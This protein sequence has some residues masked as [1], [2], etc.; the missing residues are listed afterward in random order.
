MLRSAFPHSHKMGKNASVLVG[1]VLKKPKILGRSRDA[2][3]QKGTTVVNCYL[4]F[5][6][7]DDLQ[8]QLNYRSEESPT[9]S[10]HE[11]TN[12]DQNEHDELAS[13]LVQEKER[14]REIAEECSALKS[15]L[16]Q[17]E[18]AKQVLETET[19]NLRLEAEELRE[20]VSDLD[21]QL[22]ESGEVCKVSEQR[23][24]EERE[25]C[26]KL[27]KELEEYKLNDCGTCKDLEK[28]LIDSKQV[29]DTAEEQLEGERAKY[30]GLLKELEQYKSDDCLTRDRTG[31]VPLEIEVQK[32]KK[33]GKELVKELT[34]E[35]KAHET[36][37]YVSFWFESTHSLYFPLLLCGVLY[38]RSAKMSYRQF[39]S[40]GIEWSGHAYWS[41]LKLEE[42]QFP[43]GTLHYLS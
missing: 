20:K 1:T 18:N 17:L 34:E 40:Q 37:R 2:Q 33:E 10:N 43:C 31:S 16:E 29:S 6:Q 21:R 11:L 15:S 9:E 26:K 27:L 7:M 39:F 5:L 36:L 38:I 22:V 28:R 13:Q 30:K 12:N 25:R 23:L 8:Y 35:R 14:A 4:L 32:A 24:Q 41:I 19:Q 3:L 42:T